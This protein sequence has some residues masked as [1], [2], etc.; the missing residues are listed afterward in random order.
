MGAKRVEVVKQNG[1]KGMGFKVATAI[2][3]ATK[4][5]DTLY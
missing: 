2:V 5:L 4:S 3:G 1:K